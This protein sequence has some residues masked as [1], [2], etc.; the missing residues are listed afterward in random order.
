MEPAK[1][2]L[3]LN[4]YQDFTKFESNPDNREGYMHRSNTLDYVFII[5]GELELTLDSGEKRVMKRGD[6][7]ISARSEELGQDGD[8]KNWRSRFGN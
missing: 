2:I 5:D 4:I 7:S 3:V 1:Y 8:R 6:V